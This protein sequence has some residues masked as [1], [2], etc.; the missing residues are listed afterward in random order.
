M[1]KKS[2]ES[3]PEISIEKYL[4]KKKYK[5]RIWK[6]QTSYHAKRNKTKIKTMSKKIIVRLKCLNLVITEIVFNCINL[7]VYD[8]HALSGFCCY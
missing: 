8:N 5:E 6:K 4:K 2:E 1:I 3:K 7:I